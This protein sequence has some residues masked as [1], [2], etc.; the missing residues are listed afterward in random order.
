MKPPLN[1]NAIWLGF[2]RTNAG[3]SI[4]RWKSEHS[5]SRKQNDGRRR[6]K[7]RVVWRS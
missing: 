2:L 1:G 4:K 7:H 5:K 3:S 6:L